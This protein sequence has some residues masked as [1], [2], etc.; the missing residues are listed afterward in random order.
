MKSIKPGRGPSMMSGISSVFVGIFGVIWT[1]GAIAMGAPAIFPLFGLFFVGF[2]IV[3]AVYNFK[4]ATSKNRYSSFDIVDGQEEP[5]PWNERF[6]AQ[7][8]ADVSPWNT[9]SA[10][11]MN[12]CPYCGTE[13]ENGFSFCP[14]CGKELPK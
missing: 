14:K 12:F 13:L 1:F 11:D 4:N 7:P 5:D 10:E 9:D 6:G 8:E 2:A 3:Q